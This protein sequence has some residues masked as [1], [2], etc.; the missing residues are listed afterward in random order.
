MRTDIDNN[1]TDLEKE[2]KELD[3]IGDAAMATLIE[4]NNEIEFLNE[5]LEKEEKLR[6]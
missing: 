5:Q 3:S 2:Y 4:R 6:K 1:E